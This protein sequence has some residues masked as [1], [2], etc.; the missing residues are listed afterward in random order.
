MSFREIVGN[1][2]VAISANYLGKDGALV[3][4]TSSQQVFVH[5]GITPGG[6]LVGGGVMVSRV[7]L[8]A[9]QIRA[10]NVTPISLVAAPGPGKAN[11]LLQ[12]VYSYA[13][14]TVAY[15]NTNGLGGYIYFG[16]LSG[17]IVDTSYVSQY[18]DN[19]VF[20]ALSSSA[21][22]SLNN[23]QNITANAPLVYG[24]GSYT[25]GDGTG[26]ITVVYYIVTL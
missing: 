19:E 16:S 20:T 6:T 13:Y 17:P 1:L 8:T 9:A 10:S 22:V 24:G 3:I 12:A 26:S 23:Y 2:K 7:S 18:A 4:D 5:N 21:T 14:G 15:T 11:M 25:G